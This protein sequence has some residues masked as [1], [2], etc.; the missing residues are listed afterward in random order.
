MIE[1]NFLQR[2]KANCILLNTG[3]GSVIDFED[4]KLYG[5][6]LIWCLDVFENEPFIDFAVLDEALIA[7]PHIAGYSEQAKYRGIK[8][9]YQSA[10]KLNIIHH[11]VELLPF[12]RKNISFHRINDWRDVVLT[13]YDPYLT[14]AKLKSQMIE[15]PDHAFDKMRNEFKERSEFTFIDLPKLDL[16]EKDIEVL[17]VLNFEI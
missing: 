8:M 3:R 1:K 17:R 15:D 12:P 7:T 11:D 9:I 13:T 4:L 14:S 5:G 16:K 6:H 10:R 2:Q